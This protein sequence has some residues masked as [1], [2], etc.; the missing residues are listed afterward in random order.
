MEQ[1]WHRYRGR[2]EE[3]LPAQVILASSAARH[4]WERLPAWLLEIALGLL[5]GALFIAGWALLVAWKH[6]PAYILPA[7]EAVWL[8]F[9]ELA[10]SGVLWRHT[11]ASVEEIA[12]GLALGLSTAFLLGYFLARFAFWERLLF[13]YLVAAQAVPVI[14]IAPLILIWLG[15]GLLAKTVICALTLFFPVLVNSVVG[16]RSIDD[17]LRLLMRALGANRWQL[18]TKLEWPAALPLL[19]GGLKIGVA[20][21]VIG[22]VVGEFM[23]ANQG[24]G[25]LINLAARGTMDTTML[26]V[27]IFMLVFIAVTLY[28]LVALLEKRALRWQP[29]HRPR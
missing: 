5:L 27:A 28:G 23:G 17:T 15:N 3:P 4:K 21:S 22:A 19:F 2:R 10:R 14:A 9:L 24:L 29:Q 26:F 20:L 6:Y 12:G 13:P 25:F 1:S 11:L 18:F 8:R 16:L 7:P